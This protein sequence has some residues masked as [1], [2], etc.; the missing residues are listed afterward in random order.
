MRV[1][2]VHVRTY[3]C[4]CARLYVMYACMLLAIVLSSGY[5]RCGF[6]LPGLLDSCNLY[7]GCSAMLRAWGAYDFRGDFRE[8]TT[9]TALNRPY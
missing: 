5:T 4:V 6:A 1:L 7:R 9:Y 8:P 3:V 2:R